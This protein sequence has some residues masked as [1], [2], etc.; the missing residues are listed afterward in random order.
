MPEPLAY[1]I[2]AGAI[3]PFGE[4]C[5]DLEQFLRVGKPKFQDILFQNRPFP[6]G[7]L[8]EKVEA[9]IASLHSLNRK[10]DKSVKL[11]YLAALEAIEAY[12]TLA[13][14]K[15]GISMGTSRGPTRNWEKSFQDFQSNKP[16][17]P[18]ASPSTTPGVLSSE[19]AAALN[20]TGPDLTVSMT[21][22]SS[23]ASILNGLAWLKTGWCDYYLA[24]G[25]EAALTEFTLAQA[26]ALH[27][28][29]NN[30]SQEDWPCRPL[31]FN[32]SSNTL[33]LS[34]AAAAVLLSLDPKYKSYPF[35]S[36]F[37]A[38]REEL[39]SPAGI[40]LDGKAFKNSM[41]QA[42]QFSP[43]KVDVIL[44]HAPGTILGDKAEFQA[45]QEVFNPEDMPILYPLKAWVGHSY[46]ASGALAVVAALAMFSNSFPLPDYLDQANKYKNTT[47]T[48]K[49]I[50]LNTAGFGGQSISLLI[51]KPE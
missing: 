27:L 10:A 44:V 2:G 31:D 46:G 37:G 50:L 40:S 17:S 4:N 41:M 7:L 13:Q 11:A 34:E 47:L 30:S 22:S 32:K 51:E 43:G 12:P 23:F 21:C 8:P 14:F 28:Y 29:S 49:R 26:E 1:L 42:L 9:K 45:I 20:L 35:I 16:I 38:A 48:A 6:A 19:I 24:G 33:V 39:S 36:G 5:F 3:G 15:T 25:A 18:F